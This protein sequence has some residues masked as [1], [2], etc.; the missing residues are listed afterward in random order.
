MKRGWIVGG[1]IMFCF[2][3]KNVYIMSRRQSVAGTRLSL[4]G[5]V[6]GRKSPES[7]DVC[8]RGGWRSCWCE[9]SR[10]RSNV[11]SWVPR[12]WERGQGHPGRRGLYILG[13]GVPAQ[14]DA[15]VTAA[16]FILISSFALMTLFSFSFIGECFSRC[17]R[18]GEGR[19]LEL[20]PDAV[21]SFVEKWRDVH[22][23]H[24]W[25][26]HCAAWGQRS[27]HHLGRAG[28]REWQNKAD[29]ASHSWDLQK[30]PLKMELH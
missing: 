16:G 28:G 8:P 5:S 12:Q 22:F 2:S 26:C 20:E 7:S 30:K 25:W 17:E 21:F 23:L 1:K 9:C 15:P 19:K 4:G 6:A 24:H 18:K 29:V 11:S 27:H 14:W 10:V 3:P 13:A